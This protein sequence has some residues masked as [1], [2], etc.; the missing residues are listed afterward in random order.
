VYDTVAQLTSAVARGQEPAVEAF[1]RRFFD[2]LYAH[3][4][5]VSRRDESF[6]LD[7]VQDAMLR[8]IRTIRPV[9]TEGQ[10]VAWL[11]LI[12]K[13]VTYDTL[14]GERRRKGREAARGAVVNQAPPE[15]PERLAWLREQL[16]A[17]DPPLVRLIEL[18]FVHGWTLA[19][20]AEFLGLSVGT[21]DG[22]LRRA[23]DRIRRGA[24][25]LPNE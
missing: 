18:R 5:Q 21:V 2:L 16:L 1:Y 7:V 6:C 17:L 24:G 9:A 8:I 12:V 13:S 10:L 11:K 22:R 23:L 19:R 25:E 20:I 4:R 3:A 15:E 14:R